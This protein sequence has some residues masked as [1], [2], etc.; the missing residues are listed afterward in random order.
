MRGGFRGDDFRGVSGS[1]TAEADMPRPARR[2]VL[3]YE[4]EYTAHRTD[5]RISRAMQLHRTV[6]R[7]AGPNLVPDADGDPISDGALPRLR[8]RP[9]EGRAI[10]GSA[11]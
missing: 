11:R 3:P 4:P 10:F 5:S 6:Q 1:M 9:A 7:V 8:G 2:F